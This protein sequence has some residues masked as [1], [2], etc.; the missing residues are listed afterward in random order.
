[1]LTQFATTEVAIQKVDLF[2]SIGI[3]WKLLLLQTAAFLLLLWFLKK[4]VYPS[5]VAM[6]DRREKQIEE[7]IKAAANA[8]KNALEA[9][10]RT[11]TIMKKARREADE[12][13]A[14]AKDEAA[15]LVETAEKKSREKAER[16]VKDAEAEIQN[17]IEKARVAL[18]KQTI[19]LVAVATEK[20]VGKAVAAD[21]D[22]KLIKSA[23]TEADK[24]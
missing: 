11:T 4:F 14:S 15:I 23:V 21:V 20:V 17:D 9:Q 16:I 12:L 24:S 18:K 6:L 8:E 7:S 13:L 19:E 5:L 3:D 2:S 10:E 1:M 22:E